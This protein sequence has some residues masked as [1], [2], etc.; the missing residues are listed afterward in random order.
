MNRGRPT[1][2][3]GGDAGGSAGELPPVLAMGDIDRRI[4]Q[5]FDR[6]VLPIVCCLY[7]LSYLDR[8]NIGNAKTAG[9][10]ESLGLSSSD[11]AWVLNSFYIAYILFEWTTMLWKVFPAHIFVS[12]LCLCWGAA[13]MC[14]GAAKNLTELVVC[15]V[16]LGAFEATFGAGAPFFLSCIYRRRELGLRMSLLLGMSPLASTFASSLAYGITHIRGSLEPWRLLF[17]I[18]G[19]PTIIFAPVVYFFLIDSP[20]TAKFLT[21]EERTFA[22]GRLQARDN[23]SKQAV[24]WKQII[25]GIIDYKNYVHAI[26]HFCCNFSFAALSNFLPTIVNNMGYD[27]ITAQGLTAPVYF[28]A[29]LLCVSTAFISDRYGNRGYIVATFAAIGAVGFGLLAGVQD[30]DRTGPR[31]TGVW[32]AACGIFPALCLNITWLL[33]N[34]GGDSKKGAGLAISLTIGQCSSLISSAVFP[35]EDAPFFVK[36]CALGCGFSALVVLLSLFMHFALKRENKRKQELYGPVDH[37]VEV[38]ISEQGDYDRNFR[39]LT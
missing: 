28:A 32:L 31:Y 34:Q 38:D 4:T 20:A 33:N 30:M 18:E 39:Y 9:A 8:G 36:G 21:E 3:I 37:E 22:A 35:K 13:A 26:I 6:R 24:S 15:R 23:K 16:F 10:Q 1:T 27:S 14:S 5:A 29:F 2:T 12:I 7:V 25:A 19:V 11:W 17:I